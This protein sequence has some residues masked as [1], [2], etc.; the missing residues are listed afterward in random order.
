MYVRLAF[1]VAAH[2]ESE[3]L[4]VDEVLAVG[5]T[6]FQRKC[7]GKMKDVASG[8]KTVLFVSHNMA[9][10]ENLCTGLLLL[11]G[12]LITHRGDVESVLATYKSSVIGP[13]VRNPLAQ[14]RDRAGTGRMRLTGYRIENI[15]GEIIDRVYSGQ[16]FSVVLS[17]L[18][19]GDIRRASIDVGVSIGWGDQALLA[20]MYS[21]YDGCEINGLS[22]SGEIRCVIK[23]L[24]LAA[25]TY[26]LG[27]RILADGAEADWPRDGIGELVV[28]HGDFYK[29]GSTGHGSSAPMLIRA[30]WVPSATVL[31]EAA[32]L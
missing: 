13:A 5:D 24:P 16:D 2:L 4:I 23:D 20:V 3:I 19:Q 11:Q 22:P 17:Y 21:S 6:E 32:C 27:A 12:G 15:A 7:L 31:Q 8:G 10:I 14:R 26:V 9:A 30:S 28:E 18:G 1:A 25:A 29:T